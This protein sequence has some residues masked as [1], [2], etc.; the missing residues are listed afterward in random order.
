MD[1]NT[2][3]FRGRKECPQPAKKNPA[4]NILNGERLDAFPVPGNSGSLA[5]TISVQ[6]CT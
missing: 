5:F 6:H 1:K 4:D 3:S 2:Q